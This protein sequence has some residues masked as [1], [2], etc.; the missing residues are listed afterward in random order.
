M[1]LWLASN[2]SGRGCFRGVTMSPQTMCLI[3]QSNPWSYCMHWRILG[4][5]SHN[6]IRPPRG[7]KLGKAAC[8]CMYTYVCT[9][10]YV[11][12]YSIGM[13]QWE[14][15]SLQPPLPRVELHTLFPLLRFIQFS[16]WE[17]HYS[18]QLH[19]EWSLWMSN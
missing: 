5:A 15:S 6:C 1:P 3:E 9:Y 10:M 13:Q 11:R 2:G 14:W 8:T 17:F 12:T 7:R 4:D 18:A 16:T 19:S